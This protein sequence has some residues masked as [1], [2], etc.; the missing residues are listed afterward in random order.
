MAVGEAELEAAAVQFAEDFDPRYGGFGTA[1]K[2]PPATGLS[3]LLRRYHRMND[4]HTLL[5][6][7]KT[8]DAMAA[9][10]LYDQI[11]GGFSRE[12]T[13]ESRLGPRLVEMPLAKGLLAPASPG[14]PPVA[15]RGPHRPRAHPTALRRSSRIRHAS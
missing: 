10:G 14:T 1:P 15:G 12:S 13:G 8:L 6:V 7:R 11:G 2:F 5:M 3:L 4:P 9:G